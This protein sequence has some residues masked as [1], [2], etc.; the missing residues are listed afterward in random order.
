MMSIVFN[1]LLYSKLWGSISI[2]DT[3]PCGFLINLSKNGRLLIEKLLLLHHLVQFGLELVTP[4]KLASSASTPFFGAGFGEVQSSLVQVGI[5]APWPPHHPQPPQHN[6]PNRK[7]SFSG[8]K[9]S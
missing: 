6:H 9:N 8:R 5:I 1:T 7:M 3:R 2:L 4:A